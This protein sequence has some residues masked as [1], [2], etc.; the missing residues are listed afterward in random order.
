MI[1]LVALASNTLNCL[2]Y[3][4][5]LQKSVNI[6]YSINCKPVDKDIKKVLRLRTLILCDEMSEASICEVNDYIRE[7][8]YR[9]G[10]DTD[11]IC[12]T[13]SSNICDFDITDT[14]PENDPCLGKDFIIFI[15]NI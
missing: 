12:D 7:A 15:Q 9:Y 14:T 10:C 6:L 11:K 2:L 4:L 5:A 13:I 3:R 8:S 1:Q